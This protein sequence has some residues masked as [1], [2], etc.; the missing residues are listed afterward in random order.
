LQAHETLLSS[1]RES[2]YFWRNILF[3]FTAWFWIIYLIII[4]V[5]WY[6][7]ITT[8]IYFSSVKL[9]Q[10]LLDSTYIIFVHPIKWRQPITKNLGVSWHNYKVSNPRTLHRLHILYLPPRMIQFQTK[11][12]C[13][14]ILSHHNPTR[15]R[16]QLN[17]VRN[18][19][20]ISSGLMDLK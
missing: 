10:T 16:T 11:T 14:A 7:H 20:P 4:A 13:S 3:S 6:W 2:P 19:Q 12:F 8:R 1:G 15:Q 9:S 18:T 5:Y 17:V